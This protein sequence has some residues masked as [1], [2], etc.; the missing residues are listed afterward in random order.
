MTIVIRA[1]ASGRG[2]VTE[3]EL[4]DVLLATWRDT[5]ITHVLL[6]A[7]VE[8]ATHLMGESM[9]ATYDM[10]TRK[11]VVW[12]VSDESWRVEI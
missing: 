6:S 1:P 7:I 12:K 9:R 5:A 8:Q 11:T 2:E 4:R 10:R 3:D